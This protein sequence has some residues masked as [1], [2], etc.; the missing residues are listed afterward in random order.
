MVAVQKYYTR[1]FDRPL[2]M[3]EAYRNDDC[4]NCHGGSIK[5][6][7]NH[8]DSKGAIPAGGL[9]APGLSMAKR[10]RRTRSGGCRWRRRCRGSG[11]LRERRISQWACADKHRPEER[12]S[13][14]AGATYPA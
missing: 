13:N 14:C 1:S 3:R 8:A 4:L 5:W 2:T 9:G 10:I 12:D 6:S 11:A 7:A